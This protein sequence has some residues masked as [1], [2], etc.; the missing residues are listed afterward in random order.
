[1]AVGSLNHIHLPTYEYKKTTEQI[2]GKR[3]Y[4]GVGQHFGATG[5]AGT[6]KPASMCKAT[7]GSKTTRSSVS[8]TKGYVHSHISLY[9][10]LTAVHSKSL[11]QFLDSETSPTRLTTKLKGE[12]VERAWLR[13]DNV[14]VGE[15]T[16]HFLSVR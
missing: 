8:G 9:S 7:A 13:G 3:K 14:R 16:F 12:E 1:M 15:F 5:H 10:V 11:H 6:R 4:A 2:R